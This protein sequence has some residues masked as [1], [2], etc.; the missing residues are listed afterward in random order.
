[1]AVSISKAQAQALADG[2]FTDAISE[3]S[4]KDH[5]IRTEVGLVP[6]N[7]F[8][9]L[10]EMAGYLVATAQENLVAA[11]RV[12]S[13]GL[14]ESLK[15]VNPQVINGTVMKVEV[16]ANDYYKFVDGGVRGTRSGSGVFAFKNEFVSKKMMIAIRKWL[17]REGIKGRTDNKYRGISNREDFRKSIT[18]TSQSVAYAIARSIKK[19]GLKQTN[20]FA[21]AVTDTEQKVEQEMSKGFEIDIIRT[22]PNKI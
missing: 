15:I 1:M 16:E 17:I 5:F 20:F 21:N 22:L 4:V 13:G 18:E 11:D 14:S 10:I 12:E 7:S 6:R 8:S 9:V 3:E 2:F 19:K